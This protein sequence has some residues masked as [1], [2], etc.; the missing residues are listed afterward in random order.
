MISA[1]YR[2]PESQRREMGRRWA[3]RSIAVQAGKRATLGADAETLRRREMSAARGVMLREGVTYRAAGVT[4]W[5]VCVSMRG[6][7]DQ[8]DVLV[9]GRLWRTL[10]ARQLRRLLRAG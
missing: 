5:Q 6:R 3:Y 8:L 4:R 9:D 1:L 7:I 10:G 2:Y